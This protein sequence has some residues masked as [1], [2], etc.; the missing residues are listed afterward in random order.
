MTR[1]EIIQSVIVNDLNIDYGLLREQYQT[2]IS[3]DDSIARGYI[4]FNT[5]RHDHIKGLIEL[6]ETILINEVIVK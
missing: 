2:L 1:T 6:L 5:L 3:L 4:Q